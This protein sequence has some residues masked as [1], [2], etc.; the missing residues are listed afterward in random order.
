MYLLTQPATRDEYITIINLLTHHDI[1]WQT[2]QIPDNEEEIDYRFGEWDELGTDIIIIAEG[3]TLWISNYDEIE[4]DARDDILSL[5]QLIEELNKLNNPMIIQESKCPSCSHEATITLEHNTYKLKCRNHCTYS[6]NL[7][8]AAVEWEKKHHYKLP[9]ND[10]KIKESPK[11]I[12]KKPETT[13]TAAANTH[14]S[15]IETFT[16]PTPTLH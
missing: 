7:K 14:N 15:Q 16:I 13:T 10:K 12:E 3:D 1:Y 9:R 2:Q 8:D 5:S 6:K 11:P 4:D